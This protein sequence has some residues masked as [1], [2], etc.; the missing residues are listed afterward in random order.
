MPAH[1]TNV[2]ADHG[3]GQEDQ[4]HGRKQRWDR[5]AHGSEAEDEQA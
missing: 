2:V 5:C 1:V 4:D 3:D